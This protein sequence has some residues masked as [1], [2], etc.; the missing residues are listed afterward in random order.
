MSTSSETKT[1]DVLT[2]LRQAADKHRIFEEGV[3]K[4]EEESHKQW[5]D[6]ALQKVVDCKTSPVEISFGE[7]GGAELLRCITQVALEQCVYAS[8]LQ[9][10]LQAFTPLAFFF[11]TMEAV[12]SPVPL[13]VIDWVIKYDDECRAYRYFG[14]RVHA[15]PKVVKQR[16]GTDGKYEIKCVMYDSLT[17]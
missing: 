8:N 14:L 1:V 17:F 4:R 6:N 2:K 10:P 3:K 13:Y 16:C 5:C 7:I 15:S 11:S 9:C 12:N